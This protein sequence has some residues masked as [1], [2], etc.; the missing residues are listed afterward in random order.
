MSEAPLL[1]A[2]NLVKNYEVR[3]GSVSALDDVSFELKRGEILGLVGES[4]CGKSSL[5]R[6]IMQLL[7]LDARAHLR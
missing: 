2:Q 1:F 6:V 5:A 4:G 3:G 7:T